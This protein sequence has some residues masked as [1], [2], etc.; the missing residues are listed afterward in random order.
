ML[1]LLNGKFVRLNRLLYLYDVGVWEAADTAQKRDVD[2]YEDAGLDPAINKLHWFLCGFEGAVLVRNS[3]IFPDYPLAQRQAHRRSLV[4]ID[5]YAL[6]RS[7]R[8][9][10][11]IPVS[12]AKPTNCAR[13]C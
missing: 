9:S 5:V 3:N 12:R 2:F 6:Q 11:S 8:G 7:S 1:Y 4:F 13:N 10:L